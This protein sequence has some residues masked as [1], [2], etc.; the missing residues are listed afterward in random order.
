MTCRMVF[1]KD[2]CAPHW[3]Q[4]HSALARMA[5]SLGGVCALLSLFALLCQ[6]GEQSQIVILV[7]NG[8]FRGDYQTARIS[9]YSATEGRIAVG[10]H[11]ALVFGE[12]GLGMLALTVRGELVPTGRGRITI[13]GTLV[14]TI[15]P[16]SRCLGLAGSRRQHSDRG[17]IGKDCLS[18]QH[19]P[20]DG[21]SQRFQLWICPPNLLASTG[22]GRSRHARRSGSAGRA[23]DDRHTC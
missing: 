3:P 9:N 15:G 20:P 19:M 13:P 2:F 18:G 6:M 17:I 22:R 1:W 7:T 10:V 4:S 5:S 23:A 12:M 16:Q 21:F 11:P 14:P 8:R